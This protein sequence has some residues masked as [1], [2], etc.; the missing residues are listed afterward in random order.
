[1]QK[2]QTG[3]NPILIDKNL[4]PES[5]IRNN[6]YP[7]MS[8]QI[9][10]VADFGMD[11][12]KK[13]LELIEVLVLRRKKIRDYTIN[14]LD[15][16]ILDCRNQILNIAEDDRMLKNDPERQKLSALWFKT[17]LDLEQQKLSEHKEQFRDSLFLRNEWI[18]SLLLYTEEKK[19]S[20]IIRR[21]EIESRNDLQ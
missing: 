4:N 7:A 21:I 3:I 11:L 20:D 5:T 16:L 19:L 6:L 18:K 13:R 10:S 17:I 1:V 15:D 12:E 2:N 8:Y 14:R 9:N